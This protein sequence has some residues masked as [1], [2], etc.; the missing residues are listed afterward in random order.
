MCQNIYTDLYFKELYQS[1]HYDLRQRTARLDALESSL[2]IKQENLERRHMEI[3]AKEQESK[4]LIN[5][6]EVQLSLTK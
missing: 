6:A 2:A 3:V 1:E 5:S 4:Q